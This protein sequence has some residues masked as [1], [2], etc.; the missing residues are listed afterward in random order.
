MLK[1][2]FYCLI[3][4]NLLFILY[5]CKTEPQ[6]TGSSPILNSFFISSTI[7]A[8]G[9]YKL[10]TLNVGSTYYGMM[11]ITDEDMDVSSLTVNCAI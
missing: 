4:S 7:D 5:G 6:E 11:N 2:C 1:K 3:L 10:N 9:Y 8:E